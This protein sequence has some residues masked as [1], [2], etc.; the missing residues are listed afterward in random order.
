MIKEYC[1][2]NHA[3]SCEG[4]AERAS[5]CWCCGWNPTVITERIKKFEASMAVEEAEP[6]EKVVDWDKA[7]EYYNQGLS[8]GRVAALIGSYSQ[9]VWR[10]RKKNNLPPNC[11]RHI[12]WELGMKLYLEGKKDKEIASRINASN[13]VVAAWRKRKGLPVNKTPE[14]RK[15]E[16]G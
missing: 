9:A 13:S 10:W 6:V 3:V 1:I 12:D 2:Y 8:D 16:N 11:E 7:Q 4:A 14:E 5:H 15:R